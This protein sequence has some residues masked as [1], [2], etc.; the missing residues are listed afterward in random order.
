MM[1]RLLWYFSLLPVFLSVYSPLQAKV[2]IRMG[3]WAPKGSAWHQILQEMGFNWRKSTQGQ[4]I[5]RIYAGGVLGDEGEM[6]RK[7]RIGQ[8][9]AAAISAGGLADIDRSAYALMIP[10][11]FASYQ[12]WD[13]VR[14]KV[15]P[16]LEAKLREKGFVVL[17][18]SDVGWLYF[19]SKQPVQRPNQL[20]KM[21]LAASAREAATVQIMKWAGLKPVPISTADTVTGLQT[22][23]I[24][25]LYLPLIFAE[26]S[27]L[28]RYARN[29]TDMKWAPLQGALI[30]HENAWKRLS[31]EQQ[32]EVLTIAREVGERLRQQTRRQEEKSL[33]AMKKRGLKVWPVDEASLAE[34]HKTAQDAYSQIIE[35]L[36]PPQMFDKVRRLR[37]EYRALNSP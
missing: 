17:A 14:N 28:Y 19:F 3:T 9:Q 22:G 7:M 15:N 4:V 18:W 35:K 8:L 21:K 25:A 36:V 31:P 11:M 6:I 33:E 16:E 27:N 12:E 2:L 10:M 30:M 5:L 32:Q 13:Y 37:D 26:G 23:L 1:K 29:M 20:K 34:W 24:D